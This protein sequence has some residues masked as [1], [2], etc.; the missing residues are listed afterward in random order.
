MKRVV[1]YTAKLTDGPF[2]LLKPTGLSGGL[3]SLGVAI[4]LLYYGRYGPLS[5]LGTA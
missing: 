1:A 2:R 4:A 5:A 3:I